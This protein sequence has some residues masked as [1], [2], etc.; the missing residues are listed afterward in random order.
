MGCCKKAAMSSIYLPLNKRLLEFGEETYKGA[1]LEKFPRTKI[2]IFTFYRD[3]DMCEDC[4]S[5]FAAMNQWFEKYNFFN[6][7]L[8][9]IK[10]VVED[11]P[12]N[13]LIYIEMGFTKSPMHIF[14]DENGRIIDIVSGFPPPKWLEKYILD[15]I[16]E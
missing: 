13:N 15:V 9:N 7:P 10:W 4:P 6:D 16:R 8:Y 11:D 12:D 5:K 2:W 14:A 1:V 3:A